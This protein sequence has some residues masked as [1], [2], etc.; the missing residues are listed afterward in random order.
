[1]Q[2][3]QHFI[4]LY[5]KKLSNDNHKL[6]FF[7]NSRINVVKTR[8]DDNTTRADIMITNV[9]RT[10]IGVYNCVVTNVYGV[11]FFEFEVQYSLR[12]KKGND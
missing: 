2:V 11:E 1:M 6:Y 10:H 7:Q 3:A 8:V 12:I 9:D 4:H 5:A